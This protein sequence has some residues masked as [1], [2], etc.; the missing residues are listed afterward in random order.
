M[1]AQGPLI[2]NPHCHLDHHLRRFE[3]LLCFSS[4]HVISLRFRLPCRRH[5]EVF[6]IEDIQI[7]IY[8]YI[9]T[10]TMAARFS[11]SELSDCFVVL[12]A[13]HIVSWAAR[14][15]AYMLGVFPCLRE[16]PIVEEHILGLQLECYQWHHPIS[17]HAIQVSTQIS[18]QVSTTELTR[19]IKKHQKLYSNTVE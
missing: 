1:Q 5:A 15:L 18:T 13:S 16:S 3:T 9:Y 4:T 14:I 6:S 17:T 12:V 2:L 11:M 10:H 19:T 7:Y 8:I